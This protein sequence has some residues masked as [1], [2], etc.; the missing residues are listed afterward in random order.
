M[1][2]SRFPGLD[3]KR[4]DASR[5]LG[6]GVIHSAKDFQGSVGDSVR[7]CFD[8]ELREVF[9]NSS[10]GG[11]KRGRDVCIIGNSFVLST[12]GLEELVDG[13]AMLDPLEDSGSERVVP[14]Y[15][16]PFRQAGAKLAR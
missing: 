5:E 4:K 13:Y 14:R 10:V 3:S 12:K 9:A 8:N 16:F 15:P 7:Q 1:A 2:K 6:T 11:V